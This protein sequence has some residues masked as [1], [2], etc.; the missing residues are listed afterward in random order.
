MRKAGIKVW[1]LLFPTEGFL[2]FLG[3]RVAALLV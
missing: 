3:H 2:R 1:D